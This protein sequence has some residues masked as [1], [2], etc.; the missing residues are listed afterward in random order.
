MS[1]PEVTTVWTNKALID[2][3]TKFLHGKGIEA[4]LREARILLGHVLQCKPIDVV[5]RSAD[6]PT[7]DEK[8][9][10]RELIRRRVEGCPTAYLTGTREFYLLAFDVSPAV[11]IPR[12]DTET[13]V[14]Q[15]ID[16]LKVKPDAVGL[17]LGTGSGC[18][19]VSLAHQAP[20]ARFIALDLSP[21][22]LEVAERN[23]A[24]HGVSGRIEFR[25]GDL[26]G[27]L[28]E[29]DRFDLIVSNPPYIPPTEIA[30]LAV[31]VRDHEPRIALDGGPDGLAFY[32]R[33]AADAGRHLN[34][35]GRV[36]VE[37][38]H[39]QADAVTSLFLQ[40][41]WAAAA[42]TKDLA[43]RPRVVTASR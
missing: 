32:R 41:G 3:T 36:L 13:L 19:V 29:T 12:P 43:G 20:H 2:W 5:A 40:A 22:A 33:I 27:V 9:R 4:P 1:A 6:E 28:A 26:F 14:M 31:E 7:A 24:K 42:L 30:E 15:A 17:D 11:L 39:T 18:I 23:A 16:F 34:P 35:G 10:Y 21:D 25:R 37:I 8:A 38:G